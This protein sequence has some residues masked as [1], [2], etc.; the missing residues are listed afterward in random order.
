LKRSPVPA[1][2]AQGAL[3]GFDAE[4]E[5][6]DS[7]FLALLPDAGARGQLAGLAQQL[8]GE[9]DLRGAALAPERFHVT[10][11]S[12]GS[13]AG[14][15]PQLVEQARQAGAALVQPAFR[16]EFDRVMSFSRALVLRGGAGLAGLARFEQALDLALVQSGL[17]RYARP[18]TPHLTL[19]YEGGA[20]VAERPV[21]PVGWMAT[22]FVL[23]HSL[24]GQTRHI[25]LERWPLLV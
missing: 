22:E 11:R 20:K 7:L 6:T 23:L 9:H 1:N 18:Y 2:P 17:G 24:V 19:L 10:L 13:Y 25:V 12:L 14:L 3:P 15:P 16:V 4:P 8:R 21:L 5:P